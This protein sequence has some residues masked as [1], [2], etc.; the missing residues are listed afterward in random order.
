MNNKTANK[1][2]DVRVLGGKILIKKQA[3][4]QQGTIVIPDNLQD[5]SGLAEVMAVGPGRETPDG[6]LIPP[7]VK[8]GDTVV[9]ST[10]VRKGEVELDG[11]TMFIVNEEDMYLKIKD[12]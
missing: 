7:S 5:K 11:V 12:G 1:I 4:E 9:L 6:V 3:I 8:K 2:G 10:L